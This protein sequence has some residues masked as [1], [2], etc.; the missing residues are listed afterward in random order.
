MYKSKINIKK[1]KKKTVDYSTTRRIIFIN[2]S[3]S[4][5]VQLKPKTNNLIKDGRLP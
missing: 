2:N 3:N 5:G 1:K 4:L